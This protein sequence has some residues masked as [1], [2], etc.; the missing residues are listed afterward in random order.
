LQLR[1]GLLGSGEHAVSLVADV[2]GEVQ[3]VESVNAVELIVARVAREYSLER[4]PAYLRSVSPA[5]VC[6]PMSAGIP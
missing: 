4:G 2:L 3:Q 6:A 1:E 5:E